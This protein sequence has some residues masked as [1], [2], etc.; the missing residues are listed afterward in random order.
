M[1]RFGSAVAAMVSALALA[2]C[3]TI[4]SGTVVEKD[5]DDADTYMG[6]CYRTEYHT[7]T[8]PVTRTTY[9]NGKSSTTTT[10]QTVSEPRQVSY[11]CQK[12]DPEHYRLRLK[13]GDEQGWVNVNPA[14]YKACAVDS[15]Y[16]DE[17]GRC[18]KP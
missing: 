17:T 11:P 1:R 10:M 15:Y 7:V 12:F 9:V 6:T 8:K 16:E 3:A 5:Y 4:T 14:A 18:S 13:A 2:G